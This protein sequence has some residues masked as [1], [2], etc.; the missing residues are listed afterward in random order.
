MNIF[1]HLTVSTSLC[2][3]GLFALSQ[4]KAE[5]LR[6]NNDFHDNVAVGL[7][8]CP[9]PMDYDGDGVRDLLVSCPDTPYRGL[10][11]FRNIGTNSDPLFDKAVKLSD[12]GPNYV[13]ISEVDGKVRVLSPGIE[14]FDFP[15]KLFSDPRP[16]EYEGER[17]ELERKRS[18]TWDYVDWNGDGET[19]IVVGIDTW[20]EYGWD[21]AYNENGEWQN[22]P[23]R[24]YVHILLGHDGKFAGSG[25]LP[26][27]TFGA[28]TP[29][30]ADFDGDGD[31][32][33]ICGEF[34]DEIGRAHV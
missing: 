31:L 10:Y 7:W 24:G 11:F 14:Y 9:L 5:I 2:L 23:L 16:I 27:E 22:G 3:V 13:R 15:T 29:C 19:D 17:I 20:K 30:V 26:I 32:D 33:M 28:P 8:N 12:D 25:A 6:Y 21:D 1:K 18:N 34:T 4:P